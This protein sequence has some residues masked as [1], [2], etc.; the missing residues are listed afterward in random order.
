MR[1]GQIVVAIVLGAYTGACATHT[2]IWAW[3]R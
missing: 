1:A 3:Y 2:L